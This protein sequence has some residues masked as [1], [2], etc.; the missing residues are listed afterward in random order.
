M[1]GYDVK[2]IKAFHL[3]KTDYILAQKKT[4]LGYAYQNSSPTFTGENA[5]SRL[6]VGDFFRKLC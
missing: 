6:E 3:F 2:I 1:N 5:P 4:T